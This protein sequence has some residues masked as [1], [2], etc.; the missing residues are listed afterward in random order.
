MGSNEFN[1]LVS[2]VIPVYNGSNYMKEAIDSALAQTYNNIE[3]I[4]VN[5][6][7]TDEGLTEQIAL[8]YGDKI[9]YYCKPNGGVSTALNYGISKMN[10]EYFSWLSHDDLYK[11]EKIE[12]QVKE[13]S[14][15]EN[16]ENI[17]SY[18][19]TTFVNDKTEELNKNSRRKYNE[20]ELYSWE[21]ILK[22]LMIK[23]SFNGCAL[24]IH[25]TV[26]EKC[27]LFN[28]DLRYSQDLLMW[29]EIFSNKYSLVFNS[30]KLS[31]N[32]IHGKQLT[33]RGKEIFH[34]DSLVLSNIMLPK[35][36]SLS[37]KKNNFVYAFAYGNA[38]HQNKQVVADC[39]K[40]GRKAKLLNIFQVFKLKMI[41][42]Y[43][44]FRSFL[45]KIY[46]K[47]LLRK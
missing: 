38:I 37:T 22:D 11:P 17:I 24:L 3:I 33:Q 46:Y 14:K 31:L 2:I 1:P 32:R 40:E 6:G 45:K 9:K 26:F 19:G 5:D 47:V 10:G 18:V 34:R 8:S 4:V 12:V 25:K 44:S 42:L 20:H 21:F 23:G 36:I 39:I 29:L 15:Y 13:L 16:R 27:G 41:C 28:E 35:F 30:E 7:S 43:G